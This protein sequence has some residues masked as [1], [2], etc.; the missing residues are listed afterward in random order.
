LIFA[1][2]QKLRLEGQEFIFNTITNPPSVILELT[3]PFVTAGNE[4]RWNKDTFGT[5]GFGVNKSITNFV[6]SRKARLI[7]SVIGWNMK[8]WTNYD[9]IK[10]FRKFNPCKFTTK[11]GKIIFVFP[12]NLFADKPKPKESEA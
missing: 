12:K 7:I 4:I 3:Q 2:P 9:K 10:H 8:Y 11:S 5:V 6:E 1:E